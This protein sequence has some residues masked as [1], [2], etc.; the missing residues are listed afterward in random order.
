MLFYIPAD[1]Q[2]YD[3]VFAQVD[4]Q[5]Y[6]FPFSGTRWRL[7]KEPRLPAGINDLK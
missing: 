3:I 7:A 1:D 2:Q 5:S 6:E 4:G